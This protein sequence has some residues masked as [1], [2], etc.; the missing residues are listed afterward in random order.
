MKLLATERFVAI[1]GLKSEPKGVLLNANNK[2][3]CRVVLDQSSVAFFT[4]HLSKIKDD[5]NRCNVWRILCDNMRL[6]VI[7]PQTLLECVIKHIVPEEEEYTL[8]IIL[9]AVQWVFK[10]RA[11]TSSD[12]KT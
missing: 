1:T 4:E 3:Y 2:G 6:G 5:V 9:Q 11:D 8:P 7:T 10:Y 12:L